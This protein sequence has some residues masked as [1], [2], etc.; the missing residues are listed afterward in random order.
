MKMINMLTY[1]VDPYYCHFNIRHYF[2]LQFVFTL[3]GHIQHTISATNP[4]NTFVQFSHETVYL[5]FST[6]YSHTYTRK[7][8]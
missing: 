7:Y 6:T 5:V 3:I 1:I 2:E 8:T 4:R